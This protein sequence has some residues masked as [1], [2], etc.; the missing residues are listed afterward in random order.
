MGDKKKKRGIIV[1]AGGLI[2]LITASACCLPVVA[3][4]LGGLGGISLVIAIATYK[5][6]LT[7]LG[8]GLILL[9]LWYYMREDKCEKCNLEKEVKK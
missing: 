7:L 3:V 1:A 9:S 4:L 5:L 6:P 8:I 2:G